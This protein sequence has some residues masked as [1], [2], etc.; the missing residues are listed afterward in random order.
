MNALGIVDVSN[1][2][3]DSKSMVTHPAT[4][5]HMRVGPEERAKLGI[6]D[7]TIRL[8]VGLE[9]VADLV[10]DLAAALDSL[11]PAAAPKRRLAPRVEPL[12]EPPVLAAPEPPAEPAPRPK[13]SR[14]KA[15][16]K[17]ETEVAPLL[18]FASGLPD[19]R[20]RKH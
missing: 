12:V 13:R 15:E 8:S 20:R 10:D 2:L 17:G 19:A 9:D 6:T 14:P 5:T 3:G 1:N 18:D 16:P 4:T 11:S 7:G